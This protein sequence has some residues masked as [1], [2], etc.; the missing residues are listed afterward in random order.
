MISNS[1]SIFL[2][3]SADDWHYYRHSSEVMIST[4][5]LF[6]FFTGGD[7]SK[8]WGSMMSVCLWAEC[9]WVWMCVFT[10]DTESWTMN[11]KW[12]ESATLKTSGVD[13]SMDGWMDGWVEHEALRACWCACCSVVLSHHMT[14][15]YCWFWN[16]VYSSACTGYSTVY[17]KTKDT[18]IQA[19]LILHWNMFHL[20]V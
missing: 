13:R 12:S 20:Y 6:F 16:C 4:V 5:R 11:T 10:R 7:L 8:R 14:G 19:V 18:M 2:S 3:C 15:C 17:L 1:I 9:V